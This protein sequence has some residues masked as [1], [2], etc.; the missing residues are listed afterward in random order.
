MRCHLMS[1]RDVD[2]CAAGVQ[3]I[4]EDITEYSRL[5]E[6][7]RQR[8]LMAALGR[9]AGGIAHDCNNILTSIILSTHVLLGERHLPRDLVPDIEGILDDAQRGARIVKQVL[10]FSRCSYFETHPVYLRVF[11]QEV[12]DA[13]R[14]TLPANVCILLELGQGEYVVH[15]N[16]ARMRRVLV[17]LAANARDAMPR[18]G[19]LCISLSRVEVRPGEEP[20]VAEMSVGEWVCLAVSDTGVGISL[21]VMPCLFGTFFTT[22]QVGQGTGLGLAQVHGIVAQHGG[23]VEVATELG[24]GTTF[25][26]YLPAHRV[27]ETEDAL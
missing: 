5:E 9:L 6:Q 23:H 26:I 17:N 8:D 21:D 19:E 16:L 25:R 27:Q 3:A 14:Q 15:V 20:P 1:V 13:L 12:A 22:K 24:R 2:G 11:I 7:M 10:D 18:G 4:V